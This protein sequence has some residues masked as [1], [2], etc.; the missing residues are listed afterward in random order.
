MRHP[1]P[2]ALA[3]AALL[4]V[5]AI[6]ALGVQF[7]GY[8][9]KGLPA[10]LPATKVDNGVTASY[11]GV[12]AS[13]LELVGKRR[14]VSGKCGGRLRLGGRPGSGVR[15]EA[16]LDQLQPVGGQRDARGTTLSSTARRTR[17]AP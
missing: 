15:S 11:S 17:S 7:T 14:A 8:S 6:P 2:V 5:G 1:A 3:A 10:S 9:T 13:P 12:S 16:D 4:L